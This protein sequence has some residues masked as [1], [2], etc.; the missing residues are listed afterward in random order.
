MTATICS[1]SVD[2]FPSP[3][4]NVVCGV[5][6]TV[7]WS[8][9]RSSAC[10]FDFVPSVSLVHKFD[11]SFASSPMSTPVT[12]PAAERPALETN[13][14]NV[15]AAQASIDD[16]AFESD[17]DLPPR[18]RTNSKSQHMHARAAVHVRTVKSHN[19]LEE[20]IDVRI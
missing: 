20:L 8:R 11:S 10:C 18:A 9:F 15:H 4:I 1:Y 14:C 2:E 12:C 3:L 19:K 5:Q 16:H 7:R 13:P 6:L 17:R